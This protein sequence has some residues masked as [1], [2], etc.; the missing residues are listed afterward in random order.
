MKYVCTRLEVLNKFKDTLQLLKIEENRYG[1]IYYYDNLLIKYYFNGVVIVS[2]LNSIT[3]KGLVD[4][5]DNKLYENDEMI[6]NNVKNTNIFIEG[7]DGVGK[8]CVVER[9]IEKGY[10]CFDRDVNVCSQ[11]LFDIDDNT[12]NVNLIKYLDSIKPGYGI[13]LI[14]NSKE[15]LDSRIRNR[16]NISQFDLEAYEYNCLYKRVYEEL[17]KLYPDINLYMID[18]TGL[19]EDE[20]FD[21]VYRLVMKK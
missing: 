19:N 15:E 1:K 6:I 8:S 10:V 18:C 20:E 3:L 14:N 21:T 9:L 17:I 12:R 13:F 2:S 5:S 16:G 7:T 4:V 11:M